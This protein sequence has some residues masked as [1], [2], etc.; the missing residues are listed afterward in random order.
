MRL[1]KGPRADDP[2]TPEAHY[3]LGYV[4][5]RENQ[6]RESLAAYTAAAALRPPAADDFITIASDYILLKSLPEAKR[7]L[8]RATEQ[9]PRNAN[10]WYLLGRTEYTSDHAAGAVHAF[11]RCLALRPRDVR[12]KYNLGLA[13]ERLEQP[14]AAIAAYQEAIRWQSSAIPS[15]DI[16]GAGAAA[17]AAAEDP[18]PY[19]D[20]GS[21]LLRR[22]DA[23]AALP[24]L[25]RAAQLAPANPSAQ[26]QLGLALERLGRD[27]EALPALR[28]AAA[29]APE[30]SAP[31]FFLGRVLRHLGRTEEAA[32]EFAIV[33]R[34]ASTRSAAEMPNPDPA[35]LASPLKRPSLSSKP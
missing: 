34:L 2:E 20:L 24:P 26:Q 15:A 7:W 8:T 27:E 18:Q 29:L 14:Q 31:H 1:A 3:L 35:S 22:N 16:P 33:S 25:S 19:L 11:D 4:L 32:A 30:I 9:E 5:F 21:L 23:S 17:Q 6:P 28:R 12:A 10:A 13:Y